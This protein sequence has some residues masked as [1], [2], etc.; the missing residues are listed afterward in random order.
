MRF[1][2]DM[3]PTPRRVAFLIEAGYDAR[4]WSDMGEPTASDQQICAY[5]RKIDL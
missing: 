5:A 2:V 3:N 1:L 4:H